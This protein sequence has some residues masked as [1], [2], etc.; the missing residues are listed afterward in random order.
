MLSEQTSRNIAD[1]FRRAARATLVRN[2]GDACSI[3]SATGSDPDTQLG[4]KLLLITLSSFVFR[5]VA[6]FQVSQAQPTR[7]YYTS[8][9]QSSLEEMFAEVANMCCGALGRELAAQFKHL[10]MSVPYELESQCTAFLD[11][12]EP[13]FRESYDITLNEAARVRITLCLSCNRPVEF[14]ATATAT[15]TAAESSHAGGELEIF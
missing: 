5:L 14:A 4:S 1:A 9:D 12:L 13:R 6:V 3:V 2:A 15:A 10:A 7:D 8:G 11:E